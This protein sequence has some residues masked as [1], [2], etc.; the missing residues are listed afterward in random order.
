MSTEDEPVRGPGPRLQTTRVNEQHLPDQRL[1]PGPGDS[2][3][4]SSGLQRVRAPYLPLHF[5]TVVSA[6]HL[7]VPA[8]YALEDVQDVS[9]EGRLGDLHSTCNVVSVR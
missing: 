1:P 3:P 7:D 4:D 5:V 2:H 6:A 9:D 8:V